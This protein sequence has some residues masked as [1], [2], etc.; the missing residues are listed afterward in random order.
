MDTKKK[1]NYIEQDTDPQA[2]AQARHDE[3][4]ALLSKRQ[5][6]FHRDRD[7]LAKEAEADFEEAR[8]RSLFKIQ[9]LE[10]RLKHHEEQAI[11]KYYE[12]D[13][14]LRSDPRLAV[15]RQPPE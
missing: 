14:K 12:L 8:A 1:H 6:N 15:L 9:I 2:T 3:E 4:A 11:R 13:S 10:K 7:Q 5:A